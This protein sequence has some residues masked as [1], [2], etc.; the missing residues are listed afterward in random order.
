MRVGGG[1]VPD[2]HPDRHRR[3][4][5][6]PYQSVLRGIQHGLHV[7]ARLARLVGLRPDRSQT[8]VIVEVPQQRGVVLSLNVNIGEQEVDRGIVRHQIA[9]LLRAFFGLVGLFQGS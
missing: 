4:S 3:H 6:I 7:L 1:A 5:L 9:G 2:P 8:E